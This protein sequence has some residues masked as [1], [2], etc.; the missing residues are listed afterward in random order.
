MNKRLAPA[1]GSAHEQV[2]KKTVPLA[3]A[4]KRD[5]QDNE[6]YSTM[7][8]Y[9]DRTI[10]FDEIK[11]TSLT[12]GVTGRNAMDGGD[13]HITLSTDRQGRPTALLAF[14]RDI[15]KA[16]QEICGDR[17]EVAVVDDNNCRTLLLS[18]P[19][20]RGLKI[21][22]NGGKGTSERSSGRI[23]LTR[24][25]SMFAGAFGGN[26]RMYYDVEIGS[27]FLWLQYTYS[28]SYVTKRHK[29]R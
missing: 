8:K 16:L 10:D 21:Q 27:N 1:K 25:A 4:D 14:G 15:R 7:L 17:V 11:T 9:T 24:H 18:K 26:R 29:R 28:E 22:N 2:K 5:N 13:C 3:K 19:Q 23:S 12:G 6:D 20:G